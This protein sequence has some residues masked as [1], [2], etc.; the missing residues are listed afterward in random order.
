LSFL[1]I[2]FEKSMFSSISDYL[3]ASLIEPQIGALSGVTPVITADGRTPP[4][5]RLFLSACYRANE[6]LHN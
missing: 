1:R 6:G 2:G 4:V 5:Q 3:S